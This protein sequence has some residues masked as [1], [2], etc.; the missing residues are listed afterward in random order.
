MSLS[1]HIL[2]SIYSLDKCISTKC[3]NYIPAYEYLFEPIREQVK[4]VIE[5]G[6]GCVEYGQ[7]SGVVN[8][9]YKT[10][11]SLR[12]WRDYFPNALITG[13]DIY[14]TN[15]SEFRIKTMIADQ[16]NN[17]QLES[18][19]NSLNGELPDIIIDD[20]SHQLHHQISSFMFLSQYLQSGSIYVIEDIQPN[21]IPFFQSLD[22]FPADF[23]HKV[24]NEFDI[25]YFDTR[26]QYNRADDF[27]IAFI[28]K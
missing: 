6:I 12:C 28:K 5:I 17:V 18:V 26:H 21:S 11:N 9:G 4:N 2:A 23:K 27:M 22:C 1:L 10:G 13:I 24:Q 20:G 16:Y 8:L 14:P 25:K 7:M 3:H 15:I 19:I